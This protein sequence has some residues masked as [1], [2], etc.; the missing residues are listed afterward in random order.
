[1]DEKKFKRLEGKAVNI[2][3]FLRRKKRLFLFF[4]FD[5][6]ISE[7]VNSPPKAVPLDGA[8]DA[9]NRLKSRENI[10]IAIVSGR[11]ISFLRN[12]FPKGFTLVG[13]HG[14]EIAEGRRG[15]VK[16]LSPAQKNVLE[17]AA[18]FFKA[19]SARGIF[20]EEKKFSLAL[21]YRN[22]SL[23]TSALLMKIAKEIKPVLKKFSLEILS[24]KKVLEIRAEGVSKGDAVGK[25]ASA[26]K[27]YAP[28]YFGDDATDED[29][30]RLRGVTGVKIGSGKTAARFRLAH[31]KNVVEVIGGLKI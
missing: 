30:F 25:L 18:A 1:M 31:P 3:A 5:G 6:T 8:V 29:V 16:K 17:L 19:A 26:H 22:A 12:F 10:K 4:D 21:H 27:D 28:V 23:K 7:I 13:C 11:E 14:A 9:L 24:G 2:A 15:S 20:T